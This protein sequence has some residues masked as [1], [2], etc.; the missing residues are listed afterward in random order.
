MLKFEMIENYIYKL[1]TFEWYIL[2][3]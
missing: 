2:Y 3:I 1:H